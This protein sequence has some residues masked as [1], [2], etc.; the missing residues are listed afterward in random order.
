MVPL[1]APRTISCSMS[2]VV[3]PPEAE[4]NEM[5]PRPSEPALET[6]PVLRA[7]RLTPP[8]GEV[9]SMSAEVTL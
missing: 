5:V 6:A 9:L 2:M 8:L 7:V 1:G 3:T 4:P